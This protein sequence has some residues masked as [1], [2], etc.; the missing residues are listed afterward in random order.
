MLIWVQLVSFSAV[1]HQFL[2]RPVEDLT[3]GFRVFETL[4]FP[5]F[6]YIHDVTYFP[7]SLLHLICMVNGIVYYVLMMPLTP[8]FPSVHPCESQP[9]IIV[10]KI[11]N[12]HIL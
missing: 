10:L 8:T 12:S 3:V 2:Y 1:Y 4:D 11:K 9:V 7:C 5:G 6:G